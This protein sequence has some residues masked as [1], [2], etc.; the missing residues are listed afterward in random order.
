MSEAKFDDSLDQVLDEENKGVS[1]HLGQIA[2]NMSEWEGPIAE[3]LDLTRA[4]VQD[5]KT[6]HPTKLRLQTYVRLSLCSYSESH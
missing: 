2:D 1:L 5:I 4:D 3:R 6:K